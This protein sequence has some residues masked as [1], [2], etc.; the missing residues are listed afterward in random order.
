MLIFILCHESW[1]MVWL[2]YT[3]LNI[4]KV[5][6]ESVVCSYAFIFQ[7]EKIEYPQDKLK[8]FCIIFEPY[9]YVIS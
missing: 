1:L 5:M 4:Q 8:S 7:V 2:V 6:Q 3:N 9:Q